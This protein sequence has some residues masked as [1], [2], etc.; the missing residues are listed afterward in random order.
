MQAE[1][2]PRFKAL[3]TD[4][5]NI[6]LIGM[7]GSGKST[8]GVV[9]AKT[10]GMQFVDTD[11]LIQQK[12]G[13][14]LQETIDNK[15]IDAF[16]EAEEEVLSGLSLKSFVIATG[17]SAVLSR[18]AMENL[19]KN[20]LTVFLDVPLSELE[21]RITNITCRGI[22]M[23]KGESF[24]SVYNTRL[25]LYRKFADITISVGNKTLEETVNL[26][27]DRIN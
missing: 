9:L 17:G 2:Q 27:I 6:V 19:K 14:K 10:L 15:G 20:A 11:L 7:A 16:L 24:E 22:A 4:M 18:T 21:K 3:K 5:K 25:P 26:I 13:E 12:T 1:Y 23:K 8:I